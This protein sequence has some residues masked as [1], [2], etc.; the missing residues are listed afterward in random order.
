VLPTPKI[1]V[2]TTLR[3]KKRKEQL[4]GSPCQAE[5]LLRNKI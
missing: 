3:K 5:P 1:N 2:I 4:P